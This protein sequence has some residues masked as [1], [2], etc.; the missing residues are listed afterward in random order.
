MQ[1]LAK[2]PG[3]WM[4]RVRLVR[5]LIKRD[6]ESLKLKFPDEIDK[7]FGCGL[8]DVLDDIYP[9][10]Y[11]LL[12]PTD[13]SNLYGTVKQWAA[14]NRS[15]KLAVELQK[16]D[17]LSKLA[18][19]PLQDQ[20]SIDTNMEAI[21]R[22]ICLVCY[23]SQGGSHAPMGL[24]YKD[25]PLPEGE[26]PR[27]ENGRVI[28]CGELS[29]VQKIQAFF[30]ID[31]NYKV[32][33]LKEYVRGLSTNTADPNSPWHTVSQSLGKEEFIKRVRSAQWNMVDRHL[34]GRD[35]ERG[36]RYCVKTSPFLINPDAPNDP[37]LT[38]EVPDYYG[39]DSAALYDIWQR[40]YLPPGADVPREWYAN[41]DTGTITNK[42]WSPSRLELVEG[43]EGNAPNADQLARLEILAEM[44]WWGATGQAQP[45]FWSGILGGR[46]QMD[47]SP[48][49]LP[50]LWPRLDDVVG[51][52]IKWPSGNGYPDSS[53]PFA[54]RQPVIPSPPVL[55]KAAID[56]LLTGYSAP[57]NPDL[58]RGRTNEPQ[59]T[60][61]GVTLD[62][63][64]R[65][66]GLG[67]YFDSARSDDC[68]EMLEVAE[69]LVSLADQRENFAIEDILVDDWTVCLV[70]PDMSKADKV[71]NPWTLNAGLQSRTQPHYRVKGKIFWNY[72]GIGFRW[73]LLVFASR[74]KEIARR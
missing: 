58:T 33:S 23:I 24:Q 20:A 5:G 66:P 52:G 31:V 34:N 41:K 72:L 68:D 56:F 16:F 71:P 22:F 21:T 43:I 40:K 53:T 45:V 26:V 7:L 61:L 14:T 48:D 50:R 64:A 36:K 11:I 27:E 9:T 37:N 12:R 51:P 4:D 67:E 47:P 28:A 38:V 49:Q 18:A 74:N 19:M 55:S 73:G 59:S 44:S 1:V 25:K 30:G 3:A 29:Q 57:F 69:G 42:R 17:S 32:N 13:I 39:M 62:Q 60:S 10:K 46:E 65:I 15:S 2:T 6:V 54:P 8:G 63:Q 35:C 70:T